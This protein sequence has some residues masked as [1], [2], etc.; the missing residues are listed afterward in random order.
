MDHENFFWEGFDEKKGKAAVAWEVC[1][2]SK[3]KGGL[4]I[5]GLIEKNRAL[6]AKWLWRF[7]LEP[8]T[9]GTRWSQPYTGFKETDGTPRTCQDALSIVLGN[10]FSRSRK[11]FLS[12]VSGWFEM[13]QK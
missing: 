12:G 8:K 1:C 13:A 3:E 5:G 4:G 2:R 6:L 9:S 10:Q 7:L 11:T